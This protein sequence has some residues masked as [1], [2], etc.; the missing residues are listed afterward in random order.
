[1]KALVVLCS[2]AVL[3]SVAPPSNGLARS[4]S[5]PAAGTFEEAAS[6][7]LISA[8]PHFQARV[9]MTI[10]SARLHLRR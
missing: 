4:R 3:T 9:C 10:S 8:Q 7:M 6:D 2:A 5:D 1:M